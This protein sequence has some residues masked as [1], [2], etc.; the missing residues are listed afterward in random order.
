MAPGGAPGIAASVVA[1]GG[2]ICNGLVQRAKA[3]GDYDAL[4]GEALA[5]GGQN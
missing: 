4:A 3:N 1:N 2:K 5:E